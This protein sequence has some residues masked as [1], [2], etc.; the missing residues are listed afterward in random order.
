[1][2][3][4]SWGRIKI[5]EET[6]R[7]LEEVIQRPLQSSAYTENQDSIIAYF[8]SYLSKI[9]ESIRIVTH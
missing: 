7:L 4:R 6:V 9:R 2:T 5:Q 3:I 8:I 1:M